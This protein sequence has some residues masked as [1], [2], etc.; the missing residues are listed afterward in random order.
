[1]THY[2]SWDINGQALNNGTRT[3]NI[4]FTWCSNLATIPWKAYSILKLYS[5]GCK[6]LY[7]LFTEI[8]SGV[9][10]LKK[11]K[12]QASCKQIN[13]SKYVLFTRP[14]Q[15]SPKNFTFWEGAVD[16]WNFST[17][18]ET[19]KTSLISGLGWK[20]WVKS[21][22]SHCTSGD[23][24]FWFA[25]IAP[26]PSVLLMKL[27]IALPFILRSVINYMVTHYIQSHWETDNN[28]TDK[29]I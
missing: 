2:I 20:Q 24:T 3:Q 19:Q 21:C 22:V 10:V 29:R 5:S 18:W 13:I 12:L 4:Y 8:A 15:T 26:V 28:L 23:H 9:V 6:Q 7:Q 27:S 11:N 25:R 17:I 1:M 14:F 16:C